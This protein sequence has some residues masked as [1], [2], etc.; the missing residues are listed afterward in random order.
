LFIHSNSLDETVT[1]SNEV[2]VN[3]VDA[4]K[5]RQKPANLTICAQ[6]AKIIHKIKKGQLTLPFFGA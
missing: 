6:K 4:D 2:F 3:M 5:P 1:V